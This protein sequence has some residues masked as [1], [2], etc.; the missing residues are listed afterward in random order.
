MAT[1]FVDG[2]G[3][4]PD[5]YATLMEALAA[6]APTGD[7]IQLSAGTYTLPSSGLTISKQ[8]SIIGAGPGL[9]EIVAT[10]APANSES[11]LL[12]VATSGVSISDVSLGGWSDTP[13]SANTGRGYLLWAENADNLTIDNV[14][15][16]SN[17]NRVA[18]YA[19]GADNLTITDSH[20]TGDYLRATIRGGGENMNISHNVFDTANY[21]SGTI[22]LETGV[23][24]SGVIDNNTFNHTA[25]VQILPTGSG[26]FKSD[27]STLTTIYAGGSAITDDGLS[28][29]NNEFTFI[30]AAE[31]NA[32]T[33]YRPQ[34][35]A[36]DL[37]AAPVGGPVTITGN[38]FA[39]YGFQAPTLVLPQVFDSGDV[40]RGTALKF[41]GSESYAKFNLDQDIGS[42]GTLSLWLKLDA[43]ATGKRN[44]IIE[45]PGDG[46][47]EF[48]YRNNSGGQFYIGPNGS[49]PGE[50]YAISVG[51]QG[52]TATSW[53][54]VQYTWLKTAGGGEMH[55]YVNGVEIGYIGGFGTTSTTWQEALDTAGGEFFLGRDPGDASRMFKGMMDD[56][57][58]FDTVLSKS[59]LD[60]I[61]T[62]ASA[63]DSS[64]YGS[65]VA[66]WDFEQGE[67]SFAGSGGTTTEL[68]LGSRKADHSD[69]VA[70]TGGEH[71]VVIADN[72]YSTIAGDLVATINGGDAADIIEDT[73]GNDSID[74]GGG[75]DLIVSLAGDDSIDGG[76]GSDLVVLRDNGGQ[77]LDLSD[78]DFSEFDATDGIAGDS[79]AVDG[80]TITLSGIETIKVAN[81]GSSTFIVRDGM[82]LQAAIYAAEAG[83]TIVVGDGVYD[84]VVID[85]A[86]TLLAENDGGATINGAGVNQGA[87]I[88]ISAGVDSV[89]V[90]GE[91]HGFAINAASG[92][93]AAVFAQGGNDAI[94]LV[95]N[96]V[97]GG[98]GHAFLSG[99]ATGTG[100]TN[101]VLDGNQLTASGANAVVYINGLANIGVV[102][103]NVAIIDN[104]ISASG[105]SGN[106]LLVGVDSTDA[107]VSGNAFSGN[108][109]Y[110]QLELYQPSTGS[111]V[112]N[113]F[114]GVG[115]VVIRDFGSD[116][117]ESQLVDGNTYSGN[118]AWI[119]GKD[120]VYS[121]VGAAMAAASEG[122]TIID[123]DGNETFVGTSGN[124]NLVGTAG[125]DTFVATAGNDVIDGAEG[126]DTFDASAQTSGIVVDLGTNPFSGVSAGTGFAFGGSIGIDGLTSIENVRGGS[127]NDV[128]NGDGNDNTFFASGGNDIIDGKGG[129]DTYNAS[130]TTS[131]VTINLAMSGG[132]ATVEIGADTLNN[133]E[134]AIG[135]S[136]IDNI[137]GNNLAN[138]ISGGGG[139]D[140]INAGGGADSVYG[141]AG[142]DL[143]YG[144]EGEDSLHGGDDDDTLYGMEH[145][146]DLFGD[147]GADTLIG[148]VGN[149][150]LE[151]GSGIDQATFDSSFVG[152]GLSVVDGKLMISS[153]EGTDTL[154]GVE[155]L[156]FTDAHVLVVGAG[157]EYT[158]LSSALAAADEGDTILILDGVTLT[159]QVTINGFTNLTILGMGDGSL[160]EMPVAHG[161]NVAGAGG[162]NTEAVIAVVNS[163][164][165]VIRDIKI[166]AKGYGATIGGNEYSAIYVADASVAVDS[167][168][169]TGVHNPLVNDHV[170][171]NQ[172]GR[173]IYVR[174]T[175][176]EHPHT[177]VITNN[178]VTD[179]QKNGIDVRGAGLVATISGNTI[180]GDGLIPGAGAMAQ[181]GIVLGFGASGTVTGNTISELGNQRADGSA[182]G[183][184]I[185]QADD[186]VNVTDNTITG[187]AGTNTT[188]GVAVVGDT[189]NVLVT[190][191]TLDGV[192][193]GVS[194][195][196]DVDGLGFAPNTFTNIQNYN[197]SLD[198]KDN[199]DPLAIAGTAGTDKIIGTALGDEINGGGGDDL[200]IGGTGADTITGGAGSDTIHGGGAGGDD[201]NSTVDT[202]LYDAGATISWNDGLG[203]WQVDGD[204][205]SETTDDVDTL[206]GIEK[207]EIDGD[208]FWLV[209]DSSNGGLS[210]IRSALEVAQ[211]GQTIL[212]AEGDYDLSAGAPGG[213]STFSAAAD[214]VTIRG[215][216]EG[217]TNI[218]GNPRIANNS[219]DYG[220]TVPNGLTLK[221]MTLEYANA[222]GYVMQ[223]VDVD[224]GKDLTLENV[225]FTGTHVGGFSDVRGADNL[226]L[227]N[228]TYDVTTALG[229][230]VRFLFGEGDN[231][232]IAGGTYN[233]VGGGTVI[234]LFDS[235]GTSISGATFSG[236]TLFLQNT[237]PNGTSRTSIEDNT[238]GGGGQLYLNQS[239][240]VDVTDGNAFTVEGAGQGI[241]VSNYAYGGGALS[242]IV[243]DG[244]VFTA[245]ISSTDQASPISYVG[246][247]LG[248][249]AIDPVTFTGNTVD[250][251]FELARK[252]L[253]GA[254]GENLTDYATSGADLLSGGGLDDII[255]GADGDDIITGDD[256][257]DT[258]GGGAGD[259]LITGGAGN[260]TIDGGE[261]SEASGDVAIYADDLSTSAFSYADGVWTVTTGTQGVDDLVGIE[262]VADLSGS[263]ETFLLV[264]AGGYAT[265][266]EAVDAAGTGDTILLGEGS[267]AGAVVDKPVSIIGAGSGITTLTSGIIIDLA[268]DAVGETLRI[269]GLTV[270]NSGGTGIQAIDQQVL[271]TLEIA[272]VVVDNAASTG[273]IVTGRQLSA[274]YAQAG[275]QNVVITNSVFSNNGGP[276][277]SADL[278]FYEFDGNATLTDVTVAGDGGASFGIQFAG[279]D[280]ES[281]DQYGYPLS[282]KTYDVLT[283]MGVVKFDNVDVSG[284]YGKVGLYI[285]GYTD[286]SA[287]T[288]TP[289]SGNTVDVTAG[290][291][292]PVFIDPMADQLPAPSGVPG[293]TSN[294]GSLYNDSE[295]NGAQYDLSGLHVVQNGAQ[296]V[297]LDGTTDDDTI[298]GSD[299][300]DVIS[301]FS[302]SDDLSG[303]LGDDVIDGG[304]GADALTGGDGDDTFHVDN[305]NDVVVEADGEGEDTVIASAD[306]VLAAGV[307]VEHLTAAAGNDSIDLTGNEYGQI[308]TGN[309]GANILIGGGGSDTLNGGE[310]SDDI[311]GGAGRD[312]LVVDGAFE[313]FTYNTVTGRLEYNGAGPDLGDDLITN[314]EVA[315]F[316]D[317]HVR[318]VGNGGF[319]TLQE[320]IDDI[321]NSIDVGPHAVLLAPEAHVGNAV[322]ADL[323]RLEGLQIIG[324]KSGVP[325]DG[326]TPSSG[327]GEST[328][329]GQLLIQADGVSVDGLRFVEGGSSSFGQSAIAVAASGVSIANS[330]FYRADPVDGD[331]YRGIEATTAASGTLTVTDSAFTGWHTG[332]FSNPEATLVATGNSFDGNV[333]GLAFDGPTVASDISGNSF[334]NNVLE[335]IGIGA[336]GDIDIGQVVGANSFSGTADEVAIY[337][338]GPSGQVVG[339]T[340]HDDVFNGQINANDQSFSGGDGDDLI[341]G[342][343]G[344]DILNGDAGDDL[345]T[346]GAGSDLIDGGADND[347]IVY[348]SS[349]EFGA[350]ESVTGG[351]GTDTIEFHGS[352]SDQLV[353]HD[354]S[355]VEE[356]VLG[357][358]DDIGVD[359]SAVSVTPGLT[360]T[361]N[362]GANAI[363]GTLL[364]DTIIGG[365]GADVITGNGGG[366]TIYGGT[367]L[368][369]D[370]NTTVDTASYSSGTLDWNGSAWT[371]NGDT[372][373]GIEKVVVGSQTYYLVD[374]TTNGGYSSIQE[375]VTAA[376][377]DDIVLVADGGYTEDVTVTDRAI[378]IQGVNPGTVTLNG[379]ISVSDVMEGDDTLAFRDFAID[380]SGKSYGITVRS[381][382]SD[383]LGVN[384]GMVVLDGMSIENARELGLFYAHPDNGSNPVNP[385]TIGG[386][387][388][389]DSVFAH[390]GQYHT[391]AK[392]QGHINLFG[393]NGDLTIQDSQFHGPAVN[394]VDSVFGTT[395]AGTSVNPYKAISVSGLRTG[396]TDVDGYVDSGELVISNV[397]IDGNYSS[398]VVSF[399]NHQSFESVSITD[400]DIDARGPWGLVNF[401]GVGGDID[402]SSGIT[403]TNSFPNGAIAVLQGLADANELEGTSGNDALIGR[404]GNDDLTGGGGNDYLI[405]G[406]ATDTAHFE[407]TTLTSSMFAQV[408]DIDMVTA[409][410][411]A[412][413]S[414]TTGGADGTDVIQGIEIVEGVDG[415]GAGPSSGRVLL[416]GNGGFA[417]IQSA[418]DAAINGDTILVA[419]GLYAESVTVDVAVSIVGANA[420]VL[421]SGMRG[422]ETTIAGGIRFIAGSEG[423]RLDGVSVT[424]ADF[425]GAMGL[426]RNY[427]AVIAADE[428]AIVNS[429]ISGVEGNDT[430]PF[431]TINGAQAFEVSGNLV[432]GWDEGAYLVSGS[433]GII[434]NN[435]FDDNGNGVVTE[436]MSVEITGNTFSNSVGGHVV[437]LPFE[438]VNIEDVVHDN[439]FLDQVRPISV[440]LNGAT[441]TVNGSEVAE[442]IT[443]EYVAGPVDLNGGGGDDVLIGSAGDDMLS[444]DT[445]AD[446]LIGGLGADTASYA[447]SIV[448]GSLQAITDADPL[449]VGDQAGWQVM[450][451][452]EGT[453]TLV[454][455][456]VVDGLGTGRIVLVGSG[457]FASLQAAIDE[458]DAGDTILIAAGAY[459]GDATVG[460]DKTGLTI[461]GAQAGN[462][463]KL[464]LPSA[465]T[466][467]STIDGRIIVLAS[468]VTIDGLRLLDGNSGGAFENSGIHVQADG[469]TVRNSTFYNTTGFGGGARAIATSVGMAAGLTVEASAFDGWA[470][471][472][473]VNGGSGTTIS[474]SA[475]I[476]NN[477]GISA[478]AYPGSANLL[479]EDNTFTGNVYE[480][481]GIG[482]AG[483]SW[484]TSSV[485][486]NTFNGV[487]VGVYD[488]ALGTG[489]VAGN[490]FNGTAGNDTFSDDYLAS[491]RVGGNTINGA[492]GTDTV[493]Y[494]FT[495]DGVVVNLATGSSSGG[496]IGNDT[497]M[498][499]E[500]VTTGSGND[501]VTGSSADNVINTGGGNDIVNYAIG[502]GNDTV[503]FGSGTADKLVVNGGS[504]GG[505]VTYAISQGSLNV[506]IGGAASGSIVATGAEQLALT[507]GS[508]GDNVT[509]TGNL[510]TAGLLPA[511]ANTVVTGGTNNDVVDASG[512]TSATGLTLS[513]GQGND[514]YRMGRG[515]DVIDG[516]AGTRDL[517]DLSHISSLTAVDL[518]TG[519]AS[520]ADVGNDTISGFED[521]KGGAGKD[522]LTGNGSD[523][524]FYASAGD[525]VISGGGGNNTYDASVWNE[526][527]TTN[528]VLGFSS[529]SKG[530]TLL[531][532][533]QNVFGG[534]GD[535]FITGTSVA[536]ILNG[537]G[538][539]DT[540]N[541]GDG[542]D[543]I[544]GGAN[545]DIL[546][547]EAGNDIITGGLGND[548]ING[549]AGDTDIAVFAGTRQQYTIAVSKV[550]GVSTVT[551]AG[552][553]GTDTLT[554]VEYLRFVNGPSSVTVEVDEITDFN[555]NTSA[556]ILALSNTGWLSFRDGATAGQIGIGSYAGRTILA[557]GDFNGDGRDDILSKTNSSN[558]ASYLSG[559]DQNGKVDFMDVSGRT[560][561]AVGDFNGD[562]KDDILSRTDASGWMSFFSGVNSNQKVDVGNYSTRTVIA[563][564]DFDGD[565]RDDILSWTNSTKWTSYLSAAAPNAKVDVGD[566]NGRTIL[567]VADF[568]GD[569]R[570]DILSMTN[571][572]GWV[573]YLSGASAASKVDVGNFTGRTVVGAG[574]FD[575]DGKADILTQTDA[576]GYL[577]Y[578]S[579]GS[580]SAQ[581]LVGEFAAQTILGVDDYDGD[582]KD[583]IL[584]FDS[585][586]ATVRYASAA[587]LSTV[588]IAGGYGANHDIIADVGLG[589]GD[590][591][592]IA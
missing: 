5:T 475:F 483:G 530:G 15:F 155:E 453:D 168:T 386:F 548:T 240:R 103:S 290:W 58:I 568:N 418:V 421:G 91:G 377:T 478:D 451:G 245:G 305:A 441:N 238:F 313:D 445:G 142:N 542:A 367:T 136:G 302:G 187:P 505:A 403:G 561:V 316:T 562:G 218:T 107:V 197:L 157:S 213:Q 368:V 172:Q 186:G 25:G 85:R 350:T 572:S 471:G 481:M 177:V 82:S 541:A 410:N 131:G 6:A 340:A 227:T 533:I 408:A 356:L 289:A 318:I 538:G 567:A 515:N 129:N 437:P 527:T 524:T 324:V 536:N 463:G 534:S 212:I 137:T 88:L 571:S 113:S 52:A 140:W 105:A 39:N 90:G 389:I 1:I 208:V 83:D 400:L 125:D 194:G 393:F 35:E 175:D 109:S 228:V 514:T 59:E 373:N 379:Q 399:Y 549:G 139:A 77:P 51:G 587:N 185:Y 161:V 564:G 286:T 329:E 241:V 295:Q 460:A 550:A 405:G 200:I 388:I 100:L 271:G 44:M 346:G 330:L 246:D 205:N 376:S 120:D 308:I 251:G 216:G 158:T 547:A 95:G 63:I 589:I 97:N 578:F 96:S 344:D 284:T 123:A 79:V 406:G 211:S 150:A 201:P 531:T 3:G 121:S 557:V 430:R 553:D 195:T 314:V 278:F 68:S 74:A 10:G 115:N 545:N 178:T 14:D 71:P 252:V 230:N 255:D 473:Y 166:D 244:N 176:A 526:T 338:Y 66:H 315:Y 328:I 528:L 500:N 287:L 516:G 312:V 569:G 517:I 60:D 181:N 32:V 378:T 130:A 282:G 529:N 47:L 486:G 592:L 12:T 466:A 182:S 141:G 472:V 326:R 381:S 274:S 48:Q 98:S 540:I 390:N 503:E 374:K 303:G 122:D 369:D 552:P 458:A 575:G 26:Q 41:D 366:D 269:N 320:A 272:D 347:T 235:N 263:G 93:L 428:V 565:G 118:P 591:M 522:F 81:T 116:F 17:S 543:T 310:G 487:G 23:P 203:A 256:G 291:N 114:A 590:D 440:Y 236:G 249:P 506:A 339:G 384:A 188:H 65:L 413:W 209:D 491:E 355:S 13:T 380:A 414:I 67:D 264:G 470:T 36:I 370:D 277:N 488:P 510:A 443:A 507:L 75:D 446:L 62:G 417:T 299:A 173:A 27:G 351:D 248:L 225:T 311:D 585:G 360:I 202:A 489:T 438:N 365:G 144:G 582:G 306:Y 254:P 280:G 147:A 112:G 204:G 206:Y 162:L 247:S 70:V 57:A 221:D 37:D 327:I 574:D 104:S 80:R 334:A 398:D 309:A 546:N 2:I 270:A 153:A 61:R 425:Q 459:V 420:G 304:E 8:V 321:A 342:G 387:E 54:N 535:D 170:P 124:D 439:V 220:S 283:P 560:V 217:L 84:A 207:V 128:I 343:D 21:E 359:A 237:N 519:T 89:V 476:G 179:Y 397:D 434:E 190:G 146:D 4:A 7:T 110:A 364:A 442:T 424:G 285:Q 494:S 160:I 260:D 348:A 242:D 214:N 512:L 579:G 433:E 394:G 448:P 276:L 573:S 544:D 49:D 64:S 396:T 132:S 224:G 559:A 513:L 469:V 106:Q 257:N 493:D 551:V 325:D 43:D 86:I 382:T 102:S 407:N 250:G 501:T 19:S 457:G 259:D 253:G 464:R 22:S 580:I 232:T 87:A 323:P 477:V 169:V 223:W 474:A 352:G 135:G 416:V 138:T 239:S 402:L 485:T 337:P 193:V 375:A 38:S 111:V 372:L 509:F 165:V 349:S 119:E 419:S 411:Q 520:G 231:I 577:S 523:N 31:S 101:S 234:N 34:P 521:I 554:G 415:D 167:V 117:D 145:D 588:T 358:S 164:N 412:G 455:V 452:G 229:A 294:A 33:F 78:L 133:I 73:L 391:G 163:T 92:D 28:I 149:D 518:G 210:T 99:G 281:Y 467:E 479:V 436:S 301:G 354:V 55:I 502:G 449:T 18:I 317:L 345:I 435:V 273:M 296:V 108:A 508:H 222:S 180:V 45:G 357:G 427:G 492:G 148:G 404:S 9:T 537:G 20:F 532:N 126:S 504:A 293:T 94:Q 174:N 279:F 154:T 30:G 498:S 11:K 184:L 576:T 581:V 383:V 361:G 189:D 570:D 156:T 490:T 468:D 261:G 426:D 341:N 332:L 50:D 422:A 583:D 53:T 429:V 431:G 42:Q 300:D 480:D 401:D 563:V 447:G 183:I 69:F 298:V 586:T 151:G 409:G 584:F 262:K 444:G 331:G 319:A 525:D 292:I 267:F 495:E 432:T 461:L 171:G 335:N 297:V 363:I 336:M 40:D 566:F 199:D 539:S 29:T 16:A 46:G 423:A 558:F 243:L 556:D 362:A 353:L 265:L 454:G 496:E 511:A 450:S 192:S 555:M 198:A 322:I 462:D 152:A 233:G 134:N 333:V 275:V 484:A 456:E 258:L 215:S 143:A 371:I 72:T 196:A 385:D 24:I 159:E 226:T 307:E 268:A 497:L 395:A 392:G 56:I 266:Q 465:D 288:F 76:A 482:A 499:I 219:A 191:N 127:G